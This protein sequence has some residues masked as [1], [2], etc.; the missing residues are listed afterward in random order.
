[1]MLSVVTLM[2]KGGYWGVG[3]E[4]SQS[5]SS[6]Q[7]MQTYGELEESNVVDENALGFKIQVGGE[8]EAG[9]RTNLTFGMSQY[10]DDLF[11]KDFMDPE[12]SLDNGYIFSFGVEMQK[13]FAVSSVFSPIILGGFEFGYVDIDGFVQ[14]SANFTA[15]KFGIGML[16]LFSDGFEFESQIFYRYRSWGNYNYDQATTSNVT[17]EENTINLSIG[18]NFHY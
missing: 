1:M 4:G 6:K 12:K 16:N 8:A 14:D 17:L 3:I 18:M 5:F 7:K 9:L 13:A 15:W 11:P 10:Q 2:A